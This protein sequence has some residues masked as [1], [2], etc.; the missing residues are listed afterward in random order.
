[1]RDAMTET[2][3]L[4]VF[5][6][7]ADTSHLCVSHVMA[8]CDVAGVLIEEIEMSHLMA[9]LPLVPRSIDQPAIG[10][11]QV[12]AHKRGVATSWSGGLTAIA[13]AAKGVHPATISSA[14]PHIARERKTSQGEGLKLHK[15]PKVSL[16]PAL[17]AAAGIKEEL[18]TPTRSNPML[19]G[20]SEEHVIDKV[21][22]RAAHK[23]LESIEGKTSNSSFLSFLDVV[24]SE[25]DSGVSDSIKFLKTLEAKCLPPKLS[26]KVMED[27]HRL[28]FLDNDDLNNIILGHLCDDLTEEVMDED[29]DHLSCEFQA[30]FKKNKSNSSTKKKKIAKIRMVR[31]NKNDSP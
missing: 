16:A 28:A 6:L 29:S 30:V 12:Q 26:S 3:D 9:A 20:A 4:H 25:N 14:P 24:V 21:K 23:N 13:G 31:K 7:C 15:S 1:M 2:H 19:V 18:T 22:K 27:D 5:I 17:H 11:S 10:A 8:R